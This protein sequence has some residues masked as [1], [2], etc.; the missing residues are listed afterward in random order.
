MPCQLR[1]KE[2]RV[3][4]KQYGDIYRALRTEGRPQAPEPRLFERADPIDG[5]LDPFDCNN[6]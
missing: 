4:Y 3:G 5:L 2:C 1:K 6:L